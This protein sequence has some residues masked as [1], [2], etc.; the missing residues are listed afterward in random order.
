VKY[1]FQA[2]LAVG[3]LVGFYVVALAVVV[4][5]GY[6]GVLLSTTKVVSLAAGFWILAVTVAIALGR[7]LFSG[8]KASTADLG[9]VLSEA[10]QPTLWREVRELAAFAGT[11]PPDEIQLVAAANAAVAEETSMLGLVGGTRKMYIGASLLVGLSREQLRAVLAH[12]LGHYSGRHTALAAL[13]YR[14]KEAIGQVLT[15]LDDSFVRLPLWLYARLYLAVSQT[16]N[17]RQE[18]EADRLSAELV[19]A[20]TAAE[21]LRQAI[22][23]DP[24]WEYFLELYVNPGAADGKRPHDLFDGFRCFLA[25]PE[26]ERQFAKVKANLPEPPRSIYDSHPPI[27]KRLA[28]FHS[29][30]ISAAQDT[31]GPATTLLNDP[32]ADLARLTEVIYQESGLAPVAFDDIAAFTGRSKSEHNA[33]VFLNAFARQGL[34]NSTLDGTVA[35]MKEGRSEELLRAVDKN[36]NDREAARTTTATVLGDVVAHS[37][38]EQGSASYVLDWNG[39]PRLVGERGESLDPWSPAYE[40]LAA[41]DDAVAAFETWLDNHQVRRDIELPPV[42]RE[43]DKPPSEPTQ[44]FGVLAPVKTSRFSRY[45]V[46]GVADS[47]VLICKPRSEDRWAA[48]FALQSFRNDGRVY[49]RRM[50]SRQPAEVL[51]E[52]GAQHFCWD[53]ITSLVARNK[54]FS[55]RAQL[56]ASDGSTVTM[57]WSWTAHSE[58]QMWAFVTHYLGDRFTVENAKSASPNR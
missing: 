39:P 35:A 46:L 48:S 15:E 29:I 24:A 3:L 22:A 26:R 52:G 43:G 1:R 11:R 16:V 25:A 20:D 17:R 57:R 31:S 12:E 4:A 9:L 21:A 33:R 8:Q 58:G 6:V 28:A 37:L 45:C 54:R 56:T 47:G 49:A 14:S 30:G 34:S 40:A 51:A 27:S 5:L 19:G 44:W 18:F 2:L 23:L 13:T 32:E 7:P 10:D 38:I 36:N 41:D 42:E 50:L 55:H 53:E